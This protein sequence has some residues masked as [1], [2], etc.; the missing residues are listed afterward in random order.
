[1]REICLSRTCSDCFRVEVMASFLAALS[2]E[3]R[4]Q[5]A[6]HT[7]RRRKKPNINFLLGGCL[8]RVDSCFSPIIRYAIA[9]AKKRPYTK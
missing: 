8:T 7:N 3:F 6:R 5:S 4:S 9:P 1:M 2:T